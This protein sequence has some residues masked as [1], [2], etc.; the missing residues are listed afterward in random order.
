MPS[1]GIEQKGYQGSTMRFRV[2]PRDVP[3]EIAA[4]RLGKSAVEFQAVLPNLIAR[5]FPKADPD[6]GNFDLDAID[7]WRRTRHPHLFLTEVPRARDARAVV[8]A[9]LGGMKV[10]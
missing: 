8:S 9:R 4:R 1:A 10:G 5:G 2:E 3:P 6:T 7:A